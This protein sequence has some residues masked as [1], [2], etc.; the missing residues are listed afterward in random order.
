MVGFV[1]YVNIFC[2]FKFIK[3]VKKNTNCIL[4]GEAVGQ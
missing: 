3:L 1:L 2:K 4:H